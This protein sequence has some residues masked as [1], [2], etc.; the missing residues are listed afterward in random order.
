MGA[1]RRRRT[2]AVALATSALLATVTPAVAQPTSETLAEDLQGPLGL[3]VDRDGTAYV[4]ESFGGRLTRVDRRGRQRVVF[5][6]T[7]RSPAGVATRRNGK[8]VFTS[9]LAPEDPEAPPT[10]TTLEAL[11]S[12]GRSTTIASLLEYERRVNPDRRQ[13]YGFRDL[14]EE[15]AEQLPDDLPS[16][17]Y[18]GIVDSNPYAVAVETRKKGKSTSYLVADA[19]GNSIVRVP[20]NGRRLSTVA[21]LP[22]VRQRITAEAVEQFR[23]QGF[24]LPDCII[25]ERYDGEPVPT[26]IEIG[27][28]GHYYVT[29]LPG[30]PEA[31]GAGAVWRIHHRSGKVRRVAT[32]FSGAVDLAVARNGT[33]YV[34]E[35]FAD[36]VSSVRRG[37]VRTFAEV[38]SPGAI[39]IGPKGRVY[40]TT[41]VFGP[42]G[43]LE[44]FR[45]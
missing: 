20:A 13:S 1:D 7:G 19:A 3:A 37:K 5:E 2:F 27:R 38:S 39:E 34:A 31:E 12:G 11:R 9:T 30:F 35:L 23:E 10:D 33:I 6:Q 45:P 26:D 14:D 25:G 18:K 29:T 36:R 17:R 40:V 32:G 28:D 41:G 44:V 22:P 24:D 4:A 43:T 15:C 8:V 42:G 21:V 16:A